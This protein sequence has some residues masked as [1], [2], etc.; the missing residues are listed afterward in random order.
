MIPYG[1]FERRPIQALKG[2]GQYL[3]LPKGSKVEISPDTPYPLFLQYIEEITEYDVLCRNNGIHE[4]VADLRCIKDEEEIGIYRTAAE[5]TNGLIDQIEKRVAEGKLKT[6][7]QLAL[8]IETECRRLGCE[9]TGFE[10]LA[11]GPE[12]S[13][14]IH[15]FPAW[16]GAAFGGPGLSILDFGVKYQGYTTDVTMTFARGP[17]SKGQE[18]LLSLT[19]KAYRLALSL[20][21][22]GV[23]TRAI[24]VAVENHFGRSRKAMPHALG[25][26]IGLEAHEGPYLRVRSE[27][28]AALAP[29]MIVTLEPGLYDPAL[30]GCRLE[31]DLLITDNGAELLTTSRIV[32]L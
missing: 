8:F 16:T 22:G 5:I 32:R 30:G 3:S 12:R 9:G 17:L 6:E 21:A 20:T 1:E 27:N 2:A 4:A 19:E 31:N 7:S 10:T 23:S 28:A 26:G 14:G 18:R 24:A 11:A 13:F 25:H 15:A 29:G